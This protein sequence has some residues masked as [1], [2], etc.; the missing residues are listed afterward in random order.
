[1]RQVETKKRLGSL[2]GFVFLQSIKRNIAK[3]QAADAKKQM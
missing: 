1:M 3:Q 2:M